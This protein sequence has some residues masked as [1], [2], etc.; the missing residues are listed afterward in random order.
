MPSIIDGIIIENC[1]G[2]IN[3]GDRYA[4]NPISKE[5]SYYGSGCANTTKTCTIFNGINTSIIKDT[6]KSDMDYVFSL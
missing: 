4:I 3:L 1:K 2:A 6:D 5:K